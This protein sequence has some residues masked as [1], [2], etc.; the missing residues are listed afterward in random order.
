MTRE[1]DV[2]IIGAGSAGLYAMGQVRR[3]TKNFVLIDGGILGTTCARVGCMPSKAMI[4]IAEDFHR[5]NIFDRQGIKGKE[6]LI[7]NIPESMEHIQDLRDTFV[8]RTLGHSIKKLPAD[9][10]I[11]SHAHFIDSNTLT[12]DDGQIIKAKKIILATGS[13]P[14]IVDAWQAFG[15]R[16]VTTN[17]IF[18][19]E[20]LPESMAIIGL[21]VI[22]LE[23]GQSLSRMGVKVTGID[24]QLS[25]GAIDDKEINKTA[26]DIISKEMTLWLGESADISEHKNGKLIVTA[27][28]NSI[29]VDKVLLSLGRRANTDKLNLSATGIDLDKHGI[30]VFDP[31]TMQTSHCDIFIAGDCSADKP[32]MHEAGF[33]GR[34]AGYNAMQQQSTAFKQKTPLAITFCDP[35][36]VTVGARLA[37]LDRDNIAIGEAQLANVGRALIIGKNKGLI[38]VYADKASGK[39]LGAAMICIKGENLGH[40]L[41]W[42][43]EMGMTVQDL[44]RMPYY[45]PVIEEALQAALYNLKAKLNLH[46][47]K[48]KQSWPIELEPLNTVL[49]NE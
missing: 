15:E 24:Q 3:A 16:I 5:K 38:R 26:I 10:L 46:K 49:K 25:I 42:S 6:N 12:T 30:P 48:A 32:M 31:H 13:R 35:N 28:E 39:I 37:D 33:E 20:D 11:T 23:I 9:K 40:L 22:G 45:H 4:Q 8:D 17:E 21:G 14:I 27:G 2:A 41:C 1:V 29:V 18:E 34:I 47:N 43:I 19:L 44:L 7:L 36:I